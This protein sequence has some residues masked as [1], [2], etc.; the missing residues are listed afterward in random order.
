MKK[1]VEAAEAP[2]ARDRQNPTGP[3]GAGTPAGEPPP[4]VAE[5]IEVHRWITGQNLIWTDQL[6]GTGDVGYFHN[7]TA[8]Q[9]GIYVCGSVVSSL[10]GQPYLNP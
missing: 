10:S 1:E 2:V 4:Q 3:S 9:T 7:I 5:I 8:D 6:G